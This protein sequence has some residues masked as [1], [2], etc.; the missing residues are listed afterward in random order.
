MQGFSRT[1]VRNALERF[2]TKNS[3]GAFG[4]RGNDQILPKTVP[5][6][7]DIAVFDVCGFF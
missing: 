4:K 6:G 1:R 7:A 5:I 2:L 3:Q